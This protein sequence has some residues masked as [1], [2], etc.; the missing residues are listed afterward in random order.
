MNEYM[1]CHDESRRICE[2][3]TTAGSIAIKAKNSFIIETPLI[4][5]ARE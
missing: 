3:Y 4:G 2:T 5:Y 1:D